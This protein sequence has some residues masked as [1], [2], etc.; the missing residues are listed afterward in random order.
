MKKN[1]AWLVFMVAGAVIFLDL[2]S[3][4]LA[5]RPGGLPVFFNKGISFGFGNSLGW[6]SWWGSAGVWIGLAV[7]VSILVMRELGS[8]QLLRGW[9]TKTECISGGLFLGGVW[10]NT[11]DRVVYGA[12]R[13]WIPVP[14][15]GLY[16]NLAD[17]AIVCACI[18]WIYLYFF[19]IKT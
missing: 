14:G 6:M 9:L 15:L 13:D 7:M 2:L 5:M 16:N 18:L 11:F 4:E 19:K 10:A 17:W 1:I 12:V 8:G 3:K